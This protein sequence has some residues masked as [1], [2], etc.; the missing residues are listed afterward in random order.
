MASYCHVKGLNLRICVFVIQRSYAFLALS[1]YMCREYIL[2]R[3]R[4]R[5]LRRSVA[6]RMGDLQFERKALLIVEDATSHIWE[7]LE[8]FEKFPTKEPTRNGRRAPAVVRGCF[9]I[10]G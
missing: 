9:C 6:N 8:E 1:T 4:Y 2:D 10:Y 3:N 5:D 7:D